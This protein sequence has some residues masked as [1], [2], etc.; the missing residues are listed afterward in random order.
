[1]SWTPTHM[2]KSRV[3][4]SLAVTIAATQPGAAEREVISNT[5]M[6]SCKGELDSD[7]HIHDEVTHRQLK[8]LTYI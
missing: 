6:G 8:P 5:I 1:M 3:A 7:R 2:T 4:A